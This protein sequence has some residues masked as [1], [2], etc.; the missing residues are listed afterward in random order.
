MLFMAVKIFTLICVALLFRPGIGAATRVAC[1]GDSITEG[2]GVSNP[3]TESYP[4]KL[5]RLLGA[6]Y[7]VRNYGVSGRTLL[8][9]GDFPYWNELKYRQSRDWNPEVVIIKLG[10]N[11]SKPQNWRHS[12]NFVADFEELIASYTNLPSAPRIFLVTPCPVMGAGAF[13]I[14]PAVVADEIVPM[15]RELA[16]RAD[17]ELIDLH[18]PMT[19]HAEWFPDT[20]HPNA[21]GTAVMAALVRTALVGGHPVAPPPPVAIGRVPNNRVEI[22]WAPEWAGLVLQSSA[23][24]NASNTVWSVVEQPAYTSTNAVRV[25]NVISG[26]RYYRLWQ[27]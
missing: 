25:T 16:G 18:T 23:A 9:K 11:D 8:K 27:P 14:R 20:V 1:I 22:T 5:Q 3:A 2:A 10:T 24:L 26:R 17:H 4:A 12:T 13:S 21:R 15:V 7:E 19:G 6:D